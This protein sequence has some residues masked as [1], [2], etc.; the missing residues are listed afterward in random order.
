M[1]RSDPSSSLQ[2]AIDRLQR[3]ED[4]T[5]RSI[6]VKRTIMFYHWALRLAPDGHFCNLVWQLNNLGYHLHYLHLQSHIKQ[7]LECSFSA[8]HMAV[9]SCPSDD[10]DLLLSLSNLAASFHSRYKCSGDT[11]DLESALDADRRAAELTPADDPD[12]SWRL[13]NLSISFRFRFRRFG[14]SSDLEGALDADK[15][16]A[17][18]TPM[19]DPKLPQR[20]GS[21][22]NSLLSR[23]KLFSCTSDL[24]SA[25]DADRRAVEL[26]PTNDPELPQRLGGL[27]D[28]FRSRFERF[29]H[30]SDLESALDA[31]RR[32]VELTP[33]DDPELSLRL[34]NLA[35]SF[36][37]RFKRFG[38]SRDLESALNVKR[39]AIEL[40]PMGDP[41]L[42]RRLGDLAVFYR[43]RF[44]R[45]GENRDLESALD[46][47]RRAVELT[48]REDSNLPWRL[49]NLALSFI[50]RFK[51][52][53][54]SR[55][56]EGAL[57]SAR[58]AVELAPTD[59]FDL[60]FCLSSLALA[61][62][63]RFE[64]FGNDGDLE[65]ALDADR[66]A[67]ELT[68]TDNPDLPRRLD[69][70]GATF[71]S[72]FK[73]FEDSNDL[74]SALESNRRAVELTP[75]D[76]PELP[77]R[78]STL[79]VFLRS[80]FER[81]G[82]FGDL[83]SAL[84][85]DRRAVELTPTDDPALAGRLSNLAG[86]LYSRFE[87]FGDS[88]DLGN[89][90]DADRHA[91][92][93]TPTDNPVLPSRLNDLAISFHSRF[94]CS[95]D[96][97][98]LDSALDASRRALELT[99]TDD[100][101][102][103]PRLSDLAIF[104]RSRFE[105]F[106]DINDLES[107][108]DADQRAIK[109]TATDDPYLPLQ[110]SNLAVSFHTRFGY[111][112]DLSDL[113]NAVDAHQSAVKTTPDGHPEKIV[114]IRLLADCC[115]ARFMQHRTQQNFAEA[116]TLYQ[117]AMGQP[118]AHP[119]EHFKC[120]EAHTRFLTEN[121]QFCTLA[122]L[123]SSHSRIV[124]ALPRLVWLGHSVQRRLEDSARVGVLVNSAVSVAI[125]S[126]ELGQAVGWLEA[127]RNL[128]WSQITSI[129]SSMDDLEECHPD[130]AEK[131]REARHRLQQLGAAAQINI[132]V[133]S[134]GVG[135]G[136][137]RSD[138][139]VPSHYV[140]PIETA[141]DQYQRA[142]L[143]YDAL[144]KKIRCLEGFQDFMR[145]RKL[146]DLVAS[147]AFRRLSATAVVFIN[148]AETSCDALVLFKD[149]SVELVKLPDLS[150]QNSEKLLSLWIEHVGIRRGHRRGETSRASA[151]HIVAYKNV[152]GRLLSRLWSLVV[153]PILSALKLITEPTGEPSSHIV[154]CPTGP[155]TQLPL[156]A[157]GNYD[158]K[159]PRLRA[160]DFVMSSYTP[161]LS[162]LLRC[163][164]KDIPATSPSMLL[165]AQSFC[166]RLE[167]APLPFVRDETDRL[168]AIMP[169][170]GHE[171]LEDE[172]ASV[173]STLAAI[174]RHSWVHFACHGSQNSEDPTLTAIELHDKP[175][176]LG[177]L[178]HHVSENAE[179]AF[180][181]ACETAVGDR[182]IPEES[183]HLAA[184]MLAVGFKGVVAT[185]W[186]IKD[187]DA[188]IIVE[189]FY[190][191]LLELRT[192]GDVPLGH[193]GAAYA[194]HHATM[195]LKDTVGEDNFERWVPFVHFGV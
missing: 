116:V 88:N 56:L 177:T 162:A 28:S 168:R 173:E 7:Q 143:S 188:P 146:A 68:L 54:N 47:D 43:F 96:S 35:L 24:E 97:S 10:P 64:R 32:A 19:G 73:R 9:K 48:P 136:P 137:A 72:R 189:A 84:D 13:S 114:R 153:H 190:K 30:T 169:G 105:R 11:S 93:L 119:Q 17:E 15:R 184:G 80:R 149:G 112:R 98:D 120:A 52:F 117:T 58:R 78:L 83:D 18:L 45:F 155:L 8:F 140:L 115:A 123:L 69:N 87:R 53:G 108:I 34:S 180:L 135:R 172:Q 20:L 2:R 14:H 100:P 113:Q 192:S 92:E 109:L 166:P 94:K 128:I 103:P 145:P 22:A 179:L 5:K 76:D 6:G 131:L 174:N 132:H 77:Q 181:S 178:M 107:A 104:L 167:S 118:V 133:P 70:L 125:E 21:L 81:F 79:A 90:L 182:K 85:A 101:E 71:H 42:Q 25:L 111:S 175:L 161:S 89:G 51:R 63:S 186:S 66:R 141:S 3:R 121:P 183:A 157:A 193:T 151:P 36:H 33:T 159:G 170:E 195:V 82:D 124:D 86:S 187:E 152:C 23:F 44:E 61:L 59:N 31:D 156:H 12:L 144:V 67:V 134:A 154:W 1:F 163:V 138:L 194:L 57:D 39:R 62:S 106:E 185:M 50:S 191:K 102:L 147:S 49:S 139:T 99:S 74:E 142:A 171:F 148:V 27:A 130:A 176:T 91:V 26:T 38:D 129:Q 46:A 160:F 75:T 55:D 127:G 37:S 158:Q 40:T 165:V 29:K 126:K 122:S 110:L 4:I 95:R 60:S 164:G 65:R 41:E 150:Q 16:A